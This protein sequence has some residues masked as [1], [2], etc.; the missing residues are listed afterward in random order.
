MFVT[1]HLSINSLTYAQDDPA[2]LA[3][4]LVEFWQRNERVTAGIKKVGEL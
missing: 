3:E 2:Y 4:V 1:V